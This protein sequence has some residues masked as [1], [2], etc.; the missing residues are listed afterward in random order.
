MGL[1]K[2]ASNLLVA[3]RC[4]SVD[5]CV[6]HAT[7]EISPA[8]ATGEAAGIAAVLALRASSSVHD[9]DVRAL[10]AALRRAGAWLPESR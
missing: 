8:F 1:P 5:H 4:I 7:K 10:Q 9:V 6:H 3:E 2:R